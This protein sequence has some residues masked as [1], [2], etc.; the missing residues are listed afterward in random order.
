MDDTLTSA[1]FYL[2]VPLIGAVV[3]CRWGWKGSVIF[4][5]LGIAGLV[6]LWA[7]MSM[8]VYPEAGVDNRLSIA[9]GFAM[10]GARASLVWA[11]LAGLGAALGLFVGSF[12]ARKP[13]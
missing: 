1:L 13:A 4:V 6:A 8:F 10:A 3:A 7:I 11:A 9:A 12:I 2:I 5:A